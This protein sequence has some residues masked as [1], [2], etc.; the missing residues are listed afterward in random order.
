MQVVPFVAFDSN[1]SGQYAMTNDGSMAPTLKTGG[2]G[3]NPPA[4]ESDSRRIDG[5]LILRRLTPL[6]CERLMGWPDGWTEHGV[7]DDGT[8]VDIAITQRYRI[9]GN[10]IVSNVTQW[11]G[12]R[13]ND[14]TGG[15][16]N[17]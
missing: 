9:C 3:G 8:T 5:R 6:E 17:G 7:T 11:L 10:G 16:N 12:E 2:A 13:L 1:W 4:V 15:V 14:I